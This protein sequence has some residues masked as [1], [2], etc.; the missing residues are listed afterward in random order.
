MK[1][2]AQ[3][4]DDVGAL[5]TG[6]N[7]NNTTELFGAFER[8]ARTLAQR[9]AVPE[10][11][12]RENYMLYDQVFDYPAPDT[13]FGGAVNDFRPQGISRYPTDFVYKQPIELFDQTK[14]ILPNGVEITFEW[15]KGVG[16]LRAVTSRATPA[17]TLDPMNATTGWTVGGT[18]GSLA[19]DSTVYYQSPAALRFTLT[20]SGTGYIE[21]TLTNGIDLTTYQGV[22]VNF[23]AVRLPSIDN[24]TSIELRL[25]SS[26]SAY[27]AVTATQGFIGAWVVDDY[28]LIAF[29]LALASTVGS[30][31]ITAMDYV[32]IS[33]AH[34]ATMTNVRVGDLFI[35]LPVP[36]ELLFRTAAIFLDD[37][38][39]TATITSPQNEIVLNDAAYNIYSYECA[40]TILL[41]NAGSLASPLIKTFNEE[42]FGIKNGAGGI[43]KPGLY[44]LF[45]VANP[46]EEIRTIGN[47]Y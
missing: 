44:D 7:L 39:P 26:A 28:L 32:R 10:A 36:Y 31:T 47:Y 8:G 16:I 45:A 38:E 41:Q 43:I 6:T 2:V 13:I 19:K 30:P 21:K 37:G 24:L 4:T 23:L 34:T 15:R 14:C 22:G 1:D 11:S 18:A 46:S 25:G 12:N 42:L 40:K 3:L 35:A 27:Y 20:G 9:L 33:F 29:D 17:I 5:L